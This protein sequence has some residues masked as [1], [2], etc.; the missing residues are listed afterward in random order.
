MAASNDPK[1]GA[2][3][4]GEGPS[5]GDRSIGEMSF[6]AAL[7]AGESWTPAFHRKWCD[8][9]GKSP[10]AQITVRAQLIRALLFVEGAHMSGFVPPKAEADRLAAYSLDPARRH[11]AQALV[12]DWVTG[13]LAAMDRAAVEQEMEAKGEFEDLPEF[14]TQEQ[15]DEERERRI[16][17]ECDWR[18]LQ[19]IEYRPHIVGDLDFTGGRFP[20]GVVL[21]GCVWPGEGAEAAGAVI[22]DRAE[23]GGLDLTGS[24]LGVWSGDRL[25]V[26]DDCEAAYLYA[27]SADVRGLRVGGGLYLQG[28][29]FYSEAGRALNCDA[30]EIGAGVFLRGGFLARAEVNF[31]RARISG[32]FVC[33]GGR[34][35][36]P[37]GRAL[38]CD[39]AEISASALLGEGFVASAEVNFTGA[40]IGGQLACDGGR[41]EA[42]SGP[43]LNCDAAEIGTDVFLR[44]GF[45]A[46]AVVN[47]MR[48]RI[49]GNLWLGGGVL[50]GGADG[51]GDALDLT[52]ARI[53]AMLA[54]A[55]PNDREPARIAGPVLLSH[56]HCAVLDD[57]EIEPAAPGAEPWLGK[58]AV[59]VLDGFTYDRLG[60]NAPKDWRA[61][62][63]WLDRQ[64][65]EDRKG[66]EFKPQPFEQLAKVLRETGHASEARS[67]GLIKQYRLHTGGALPWP[68]WTFRWLL[69]LAGY[70]YRP[71]YPAFIGALL[72]AVALLIFA[73]AY[74]QGY[75]TPAQPHEA[76]AQIGADVAAM[77]GEGD[78]AA[79]DCLAADLS[80]AVPSFH[81]G[82]YVIDAFVPLVDLDQESSWKPARLPRC[83]GD[84]RTLARLDTFN[85]GWPFKTGEQ[86]WWFSAITNTIDALVRWWAPRGG[87]LWLQ[88][89]LMIAGFAISAL[90]AASLSGLIRRD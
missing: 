35:K 66:A 1:D 73:S 79:P 19:N 89:I 24:V 36:A 13:N 54:F 2:P 68:S 84:A 87:L 60:S 43:A 31:V 50:E 80:E 10:E 76:I 23:L 81:A 38:D 57:T 46:R 75:V 69:W 28:A 61:R 30:A 27:E 16:E 4:P 7:E 37:S 86:G 40:R 47:F 58:D 82:M 41:F 9:N 48:A 22:L 25:R 39:A 52:S 3:A 72:M 78:G 26:H 85:P 34:F 64:P 62:K 53:G 51:V 29:R 14:W 90:I 83:G 44:D 5:D 17:H 32:H 59:L 74:R 8:E 63:A 70:G 18:E 45:L 21:R 71:Q 20:G 77:S 15:K 11:L 42:S 49:G 55:R 88:W 33:H 56:A 67:A 12:I 65:K 6:C